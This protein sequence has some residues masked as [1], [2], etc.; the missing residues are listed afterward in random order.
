MLGRQAVVALVGPWHAGKTT[1]ACELA[2]EMGGLYLD[3][4]QAS[5]REKLAEPAQFLSQFEDRLVILDEIY[6]IPELFSHLRSIID[7]GRSKGKLTGRFLI[8]S[9]VS[10]DLLMQPMELLAGHI[11]CIDMQP[12]DL[13]EVGMGGKALKRLWVRGGI[14]KSYSAKSGRASFKRRKKYIRAYME[15][16]IQPLDLR[17]PTEKLEQLLTMLAYGQGELLNAS[18]LASDLSLSS[19]TVTKYINLLD[20]LLL[21]RHLR[22]YRA[23]VSKR[24][25]KSPKVYVRDSGLVHALLDIENRN[26]LT[27]HP[28]VR[29]SWEGFVVENL[30]SVTSGRSRASFYRTAGGAEVDLVLE[31][32]HISETWVVDISRAKFA[33]PTKGF[34][35]ACEDIQPNRSFLVH[36]G[37]KHDLVSEGVEAIGLAKMMKLLLNESG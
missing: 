28:V 22:L 30:L 37:K 1:L 18:R 19:P 36:G 14:P 13:S 5:E 23:N 3:L 25:V 17:I 6:N 21:V 7:Q 8:L 11:A 29:A 15:Q 24:L 33:K 20:N 12:L 35:R 9:S 26:Q 16:A 2:E 34:Y 32:P 31:F 27:K 10:I 4:E